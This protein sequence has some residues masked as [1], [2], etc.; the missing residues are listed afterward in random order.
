MLDF[1]GDSVKKSGEA[2]FIIKSL[3]S[4]IEDLVKKI[5]EINIELNIKNQEV[6]WNFI[7]YLF[8]L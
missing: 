4:R 2:N 1:Q 5:E 3:E 6:E 7:I 8:I